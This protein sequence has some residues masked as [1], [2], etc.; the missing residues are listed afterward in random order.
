MKIATLPKS[1]NHLDTVRQMRQN[2]QLK[3]PIVSN[4]Q[5][6]SLL[7]SESRSN[8]KNVLLKG[9]LVL[10]IGLAGRETACLSVDV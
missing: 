9:G 7:T 4:N 3:L 1:L 6:I 5:F 8:L 10:E 2:P